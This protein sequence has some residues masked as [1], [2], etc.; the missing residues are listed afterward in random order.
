MT[1]IFDERRA[2]KLMTR[3]HFCRFSDF[4]EEGGP[5]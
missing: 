4:S 5:P 1:N 3:L 2:R